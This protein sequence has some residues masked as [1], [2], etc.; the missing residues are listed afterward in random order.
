ME[1]G[2]FIDIVSIKYKDI[3]IS[4]NNWSKN[5]QLVFDEDSFND[6][7]IKCADHFKDTIITYNDAIKYFWT[8]YIHI[9]MNN[10]KH[11]KFSTELSDIIDVIDIEYN[12]NIDTMY[13]TII[14]DI[15][16]KFGN[17]A[18]QLIHNH[19]IH[20]T[21]DKLLSRKICK[22]IK[23]KYKGVVIETLYK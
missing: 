6:A 1:N 14:D 12:Y 11:N 16:Q 23:T 17:N 3:R 20:S 9:V 22:Y 8:A 15:Q 10:K 7:F 18:V 19:F 5:R 13:D 21:E 4:F 2:T